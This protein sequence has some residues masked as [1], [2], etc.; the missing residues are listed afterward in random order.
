MMVLVLPK[1]VHEWDVRLVDT[2]GDAEEE[3]EKVRIA[4]DLVMELP[5]VTH[6]AT[7]VNHRAVAVACIVDNLFLGFQSIF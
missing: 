4:V 6:R 1:L 5:P 2:D 7:E 3:S